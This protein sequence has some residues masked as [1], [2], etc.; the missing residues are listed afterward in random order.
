MK[1]ALTLLALACAL[2]VFQGA[3]STVIPSYL[4]PDFALLFIVGLAF[5]LPSVQGLWF[6]ALLGY[7]A[8]NLSGTL[9]GEHA[10]LYTAIFL[11]MRVLD[12]QTDL[13]RGLSR[14]LAV[15]VLTL[16]QASGLIWMAYFFREQSLLPVA[17]DGGLWMQALVNA[18]T[19]PFFLSW[20]LKFAHDRDSDSSLSR[21]RG[22]EVLR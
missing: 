10:I 6:A 11:I 2:L 14:S 19:A 21:H 15:G 5:R 7:L 12:R 8:D 22:Q 20:F 16:L 13:S 17:L 1:N 3:V 18:I 9:L 4:C